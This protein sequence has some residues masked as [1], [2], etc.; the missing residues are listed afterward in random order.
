MT[1]K[2]TVTVTF[3]VDQADDLS[4][5]LS[6]LLCWLDGFAAARAGTDLAER[7]GPLDS[8]TYAAREVNIT[9]KRALDAAKV[10]F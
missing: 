10:P 7:N 2:R 4:L 3:D 5:G 6:D 8:G 9:L 1:E